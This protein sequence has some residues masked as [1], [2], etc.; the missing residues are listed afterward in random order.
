MI[1]EL[2]KN[3]TDSNINKLI[4][5]LKRIGIKPY[6]VKTKSKN[7]I[8]AVGLK[9]SKDLEAHK[10]I[11]R[12]VYIEKPYQLISREYIG[13]K[14]IIDVGGVKIGGKKIVI[15][16]GSCSVESKKQIIENA[17]LVKKKGGSILRGGAFKPRTSPYSFQGL[18]KEGLKYLKMAK[19][20]TGLPIVTEVIDSKDVK[21]VSKYSDMFQIG[22][23]NMQNYSLLKEVGRTNKPVLLKRGFSATLNEFLLAAEYI[24]SQGN[25]K[26]ILCERGIRTFCTYTRNT[27]DLNIVPVIQELTHLPI[28]VDPSHGTGQ[29]SLIGPLSKASVAEGA[30]GLIIEVHQDPDKA[31]TDKEQTISFNEFTELISELKNVA[32]AVNRTV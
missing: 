20:V 5:D 7:L 8:I 29:R 25:Q 32:K 24:A 6:H 19:K 31:L 3:A 28:I 11:K 13:K 1:I 14:S 22:S 17:K 26:I 30:D 2:S 15:L 23:R 10:I 27:L 12:S 4:S 9:T 21:L 16:A 18:G